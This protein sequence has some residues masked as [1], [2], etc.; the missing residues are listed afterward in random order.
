MGMVGAYRRGG[1]KVSD[2]ELFWIG[3]VVLVGERSV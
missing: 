2:G 1:R 3:W